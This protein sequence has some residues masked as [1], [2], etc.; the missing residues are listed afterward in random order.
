M[1]LSLLQTVGSPVL[2]QKAKAINVCDA[3]V[4]RVIDQMSHALAEY[5]AQTGYGRAMAAPQIGESIR[6]IVINLGDGPVALIN[7]EMI[8]CSQEMQT[9]WDDCLSVPDHIVLVERHQS[10]S[11]RYTDTQNEIQTM[12]KLDASTSELLQ[13]ELD[14]L[15]G[16]LMDERA[17]L[18]D[19]VK[20]IRPISD[21][22]LL[23]P[24]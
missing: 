12:Q 19:G 14:H 13:H 2:T 9:V 8:W 10:I 16:I 24:R 11:V 20:T 18:R 1:S 5:R 6:L 15:D 23:M 4:L 22:V 3:H 17:V 7:P 21:R